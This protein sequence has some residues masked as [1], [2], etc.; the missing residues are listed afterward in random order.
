MEATS[1]SV[2]PT[3]AGPERSDAAKPDGKFDITTCVSYSFRRS[4]PRRT[5]Q[6][7]LSEAIGQCFSVGER[8]EPRGTVV[9]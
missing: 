5:L 8:E 9:T 2:V 4:N 7:S 6:F 1:H 3:V